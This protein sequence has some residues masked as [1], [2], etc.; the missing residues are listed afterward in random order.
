MYEYSL[1]G[2]HLSS[3]LEFPQLC[4][5]DGT[6]ERIYIRNHRMPPQI[7]DTQPGQC[8]FG[9]EVSWLHNHTAW[10]L[11]QGDSI[12]YQLKEGGNPDY[13]RSY[14]LGYGVAML[15]MQ[16]GRLAIHCS[17]LRNDRGAVLIAGE[18]GAGK[19]TLTSALL[20]QGYTLMADD[21]VV[22]EPRR[23]QAT[24][25]Y[26]AFP[27]MKLCRDAAV[28]KGL[29]LEKLLYIN[30]QKDKFLVPY[31]GVF[32]QS[33]APVRT[34]IIL[35]KIRGEEPT[36]RKLQGMNGFYG[37][38]ENLFLRKLLG[39]E[40]YSP[41][42]GQQYLDFAASANMYLLARPVHGDTVQKMTELMLQCIKDSYAG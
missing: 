2:M 26:P 7:L 37:V 36:V 17:A 4:S 23:G 16:K 13:L 27:F 25:A 5:G 28:R 42:L 21:M 12:L 35:K 31:E 40:K 30:E 6:E 39:N 14:L 22:T 33:P 38:A 8:A 24:M 1:Y 15:A 19:S 18:S 9:K 3:D 41:E 10:L 32:S 20:Q 11:V 34:M 29:C